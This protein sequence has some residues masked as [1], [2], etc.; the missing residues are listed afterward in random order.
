MCSVCPSGILGF[1][2]QQI[3][4]E[5]VDTVLA[6]TQPALSSEGSDEAISGSLWTLVLKELLQYVLTSPYA[7]LG[8]LVMLSE[9]MPLPLPIQAREVKNTNF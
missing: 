3:Q 4:N 5:I 6:F 8:G 1:D 7:F 9:L 2:A